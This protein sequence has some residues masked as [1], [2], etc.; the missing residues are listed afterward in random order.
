MS[1]QNN[2]SSLQLELLRVY[3]LNPSENEL[4]EIKAFLGRLFAK[5]LLFMA[6]N[7]AIEKNISDEDLDNWL[8]D[9]DQ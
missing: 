7:A 8:N 4:L 3:A 6:N 5:K 9:E 2:L 1:R